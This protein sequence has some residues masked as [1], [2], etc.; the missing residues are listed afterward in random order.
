MG[1]CFLLTWAGWSSR[2]A[3]E[4]ASG[5]FDP[6]LDLQMLYIDNGLDKRKKLDSCNWNSELE[7]VQFWT[8]RVGVSVV[9]PFLTWNLQAVAVMVVK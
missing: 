3:I 7:N 4:T 8:S 9:S 1:V 6:L 5:W 2:E